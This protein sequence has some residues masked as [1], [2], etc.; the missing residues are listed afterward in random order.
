MHFAS[1]FPIL[2]KRWKPSGILILLTARKSLHILI[3]AQE[4]RLITDKRHL[5]ELLDVNV[6]N[7]AGYFSQAPIEH[8]TSSV[9]APQAGYQCSDR[10]EVK[11]SSRAVKQQS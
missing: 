9:V 4:T 3:W 7:A 5:Y 6:S 8:Q 11:R 10:W 2:T 1:V